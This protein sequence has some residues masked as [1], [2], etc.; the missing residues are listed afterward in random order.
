[1]EGKI[2]IARNMLSKGMEVSVIGEITGLTKKEIE[3]LRR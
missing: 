3:K 2:E 1:M